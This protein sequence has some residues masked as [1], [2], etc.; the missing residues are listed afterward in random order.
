MRPA[1]QRLASLTGARAAQHSGEEGLRESLADGLRDVAAGV[2]AQALLPALAHALRCALDGGDGARA[3][4]CAFAA[5]AVARTIP[6][7]Y[8]REAEQ[9]C[10]AALQLLNAP[11]AS[12]QA[13]HSAAALLGALGTWLSG[14]SPDSVSASAAGFVAALRCPDATLTR[15][16]AVALLRACDAGRKDGRCARGHDREPAP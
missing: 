4:G 6:A 14:A 9:L 8:S 12:V 16:A 10:A 1:A 5:A 13:A 2:G 7:G 3:E 15:A 11:N